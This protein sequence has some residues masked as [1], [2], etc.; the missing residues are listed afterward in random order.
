MDLIDDKI[1][2]SPI[3]ISSIQVAPPIMSVMRMQPAITVQ[4]G[5]GNAPPLR[6]G[7][8]PMG[9]MTLASLQSRLNVALK[10]TGPPG[11]GRGPGG[12]GGLGGPEGMPV[13]GLLLQQPV[14][15]AGD[16]K[17]M[18]QLPQIFTGDHSKADNF[19]KEVKGYLHLN[20]DM[21][22]FDSPIKKIAFTLML[23][24]GEDTVGWT[25]DMGNFLDGL[26]PADNILDLWT[27][28]LAEFGQQ[29]QDTQKEDQTHT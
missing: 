3:N 21:V 19:I 9:G 26:G 5:E 6:S 29:F 23:I 15:P 25:R 12:P 8:P 18:G 7:T 13:P 27:Q 28:F 16:V 24:E 14:M 20:Q 22:G 10:Q 17:T 2:R 11:S 1:Q 4:A